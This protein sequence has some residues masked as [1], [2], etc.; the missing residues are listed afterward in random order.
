[1]SPRRSL[2]WIAPAALALAAIGCD[3]GEPGAGLTNGPPPSTAPEKP[4]VR[5]D[6]PADADPGV[7]EPLGDLGDTENSG[8][9]AARGAGTE[10]AYPDQPRPD[11]SDDSVRATPPALEP[12][13]PASP[14]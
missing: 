8:G 7:S 12:S 9:T 2:P 5:T 13:A 3:T 4:A 1:M 10:G 14:R 6:L 11:E